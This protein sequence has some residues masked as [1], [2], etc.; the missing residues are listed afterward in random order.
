MTEGLNGNTEAYPLLTQ[1][2]AQTV[3]NVSIYFHQGGV[4]NEDKSRC[5]I[6]IFR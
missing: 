1:D 4:G 2:R 5:M 6:A 3:N